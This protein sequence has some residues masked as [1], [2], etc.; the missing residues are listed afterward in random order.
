MFTDQTGCFPHLSQSGN[1][2]IMV[3]YHSDSNLILMEAMRNRTE[4]EIIAAYERIMKRTR[5]AN[6]TIKKHILDNEASA[7]YKEAI[8]NN[9]VEY[10]LVPPNNHQQNQAERAIQTFK[11]HFIAIMCG[12]DD[13]F[14]MNLWCKFLP[15][16]ERTLN[17]LRQSNTVPTISAYTHMYGAH[18]YMKKPFAPMRCA[19]QC[20]DKPGVRHS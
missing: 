16:A 14:P 4:C 2:Y 13:S 17:L 10:K 7:N 6:L 11:S 1:Q 12:V 5:K 19:T 3:V 15:Q 20:H 9:K 8:A 18:D